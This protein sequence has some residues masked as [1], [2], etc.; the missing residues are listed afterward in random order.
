MVK[1]RR[2]KLTTGKIFPVIVVALTLVTTVAFLQHPF[3]KLS[4][5]VPPRPYNL[6]L[7]VDRAEG[8]RGRPWAY[9]IET[10]DGGWHSHLNKEAFKANTFIE[11][12]DHSH[13][14]TWL[15]DWNHVIWLGVCPGCQENLYWQVEDVEPNNKGYLQSSNCKLTHLRCDEGEL[16][17][18]NYPNPTFW[19]VVNQYET[20]RYQ[21]DWIFETKA[22]TYHVLKEHSCTPGGRDPYP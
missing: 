13:S 7:M 14:F 20:G 16:C 18:N 4:A 1:L 15:K 22:A 12:I 10:D 17:K 5:H 21:A 8:Q 3:R 11:N 9:V 6:N 2:T 19:Y